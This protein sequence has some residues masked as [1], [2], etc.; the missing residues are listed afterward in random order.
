MLFRDYRYFLDIIDVFLEIIDRTYS[1]STIS[2]TV[3]D[4]VKRY[5]M[6]VGVN[7]PISGIRSIIKP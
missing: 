4:A 1:L 5:H 7:Q 3:S 2:S 6:S